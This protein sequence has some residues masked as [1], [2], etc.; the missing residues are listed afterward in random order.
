MENMWLIYVSAETRAN[1]IEAI[2]DE[3]IT[4]KNSWMFRSKMITMYQTNKCGQHLN[5][6]GKCSEI[7]KIKKK[8]LQ[9]PS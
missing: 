1:A 5:N 7:S 8:I 6:P 3:N 4:E 2:I 9:V